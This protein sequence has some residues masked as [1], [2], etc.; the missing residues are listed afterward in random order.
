MCLPRL[1]MGSKDTRDRFLFFFF[2]IFFLQ[3]YWDII[4]IKY[5]VSLGCAARWLDTVTYGKM[6]PT[7]ALT[8]SIPSHNS[9]FFFVMTIFMIQSLASF[10]YTYNEV[11][12]QSL[13]PGNWHLK[14]WQEFLGSLVVRTWCFYSCGPGFVDLR[15]HSLYSAM[16]A[17]SYPTLWDAMNCSPPRSSLH[18]IFWVRTLQWHAFPTPTTDRFLLNALIKVGSGWWPDGTARFVYWYGRQTFSFTFL[19]SLFWSHLFGSTHWSP[20]ARKTWKCWL[21]GSASST[22]IRGER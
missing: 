21:P 19:P 12:W 17:Q 15:P 18:G 13:H 14:M 2:I 6:I 5:C 7:R 20:L 8:S 3:V 11:L 16:H 1:L 10:K 22:Q 9:H 4:D